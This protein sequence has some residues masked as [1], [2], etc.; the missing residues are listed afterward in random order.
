[1]MPLTGLVA[2]AA[3]GLCIGSF[4]N[5][6]IYRLPRGQSLSRPPSRC[7]SCGCTLRWFDNIPV[8]SWLWLRGRCRQCREPVSWQYPV[9]EVITAS[10]FVLVAWYSGAGPLLVPRLLLVSI[11]IALFMIDLEHQILPNAI[12]LPGVVAGL[13]FSTFAPPGEMDAIIGALL[14]GG[15]LYAIAYGYYLWR[16]HEG[17][18]MGDVKMLAMIGAFLG[19]K[20]VL[21]TL[22]F[23]SFSGTGVGLALMA[24][25]RGDMKYALPFG[26]FL[27]VGALMA[28][29]AAEP[30][31]AWYLGAL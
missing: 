10:L 15:I 16:G 13:M 31:F 9:V 1:M 5:V 8:L 24:A 20:A 28:M 26:T 19:W 12:T 29:F 2:A 17:M 11:L 3:F 30:L 18:G 27:A 7:R 21:V 6:V 23:A 22:V 25:N 4:L 14:G